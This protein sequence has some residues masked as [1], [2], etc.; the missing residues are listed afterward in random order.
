[1]LTKEHSI[2]DSLKQSL[3]GINIYTA[4][5]YLVLLL[6]SL[7][8]TNQ[9]QVQPPTMLRLGFT[10]AF[11]LPLFLNRNL[12]VPLITLF[13]SIR[14]FSIAP[15]G[16]L[17]SD[18]T[19]YLAVLVALLIFD[20]ITY[21]GYQKFNVY[22]VLLLLVSLFSNLVNYVTEP[23]EYEFQKAAV[24]ALL[25]LKLTHTTRELTILKSAFILVTVCLA[26]YGLLFAKELQ[27]VALDSN[28]KR[29]FWHDPNYLGSLMGIGMIIAFYYLLY[30]RETLPIKVIL[31]FTIV[32]GFINLAYFASR[33]AFI[34]TVIPMLFLLF[35]KTHSFGQIIAAIVII[36]AIIPLL[37]YFEIFDPLIVRFVEEETI[38]TGSYRTT[39]WVGS[40][41]MFINSGIGTLLMGGGSGFANILC[42]KALNLNLMSAHNNYLDILYNYGIIG[43]LLFLGLLGSWIKKYQHNP[44]S[45]ALVMSFMIACLTLA[46]LMF[47]PFW[48]L[49][50]LIDKSSIHENQTV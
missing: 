40:F 15:Y 30:H 26:V 1:M 11:F 17:P 35:R 22:L 14:L 50:V 21:S 42:G 24:V 39:V 23:L 13:A 46:P 33:G 16:Y 38:T 6:F 12:A 18:T 43:L 44:L 31:I 2:N 3:S 25:M 8:W 37:G 28:M 47:L 27:V 19:V 36:A 7:S 9:Y 29:M 4:C 41:K 48:F 49:L 45:L 20:Y 32:A 10:A 5:Y 34:S